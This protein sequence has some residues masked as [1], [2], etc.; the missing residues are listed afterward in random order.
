MNPKGTKLCVAGTMDD[1]AA[2]VTRRTMRAKILDGRGDAE[3]RRYLKPYSATHGPGNTCWM[4]MS[5]ND[6][7]AVLNLRTKGEIAWIKVG[8]H[9]QR[10]RPGTLA[11]AVERARR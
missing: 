5:G 1:Y 7:V 10:V 8:D 2:I 4:S 6:A 11:A 3:S 9:P